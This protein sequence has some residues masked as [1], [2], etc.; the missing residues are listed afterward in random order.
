MTMRYQQP[1]LRQQLAA[2]YA[3]GLLRGRAR[4]R[5]ETLLRRDP[6]LT[7]EVDFWNARFS[8]F[9]A[10][11]KPVSP[12]AVVWASLA[13]VVE[14]ERQKVSPI[15]SARPTSQ[16]RLRLWQTWAVAATAAAIALGVGWQIEQ[17]KTQTLGT[18]L[19]LAESKPMPYV[20][21]F[22]PQGGDARWAISLHTDSKVIR[23]VL[24]G[25]KMPTDITAHSLELW[26]LDSKG[27]PHSLGLLPINGRD[28]HDMP[29][30]DMPAEEM[31]TSLTLAVSVEPR[32]G[33]PT[34]LPTGQ[35]LGAV[36]AV[37]P[38]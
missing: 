28:S 21:V 11:L 22:Q 26:M 7:E 35:V 15:R 2:E 23:V 14:Q 3:L 38:I 20:A 30:P 31:G 37:R 10:Q 12:R 17:T 1:L 4:A 19:A 6:T 9:A 34:G 29:M 27:T 13:Q 24:S 16:I 5:F 18:A 32:G 33:S 36:P 25:Q 8:E